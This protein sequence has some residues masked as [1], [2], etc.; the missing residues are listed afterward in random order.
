MDHDGY[1]YLIVGG[2]MAADAAVHGIREVDP[3]GTIG[4][5]SAEPDPPYKR[6][7]L[8][9]KLWHGKALDSIWLSTDQLGV[10]LHLG[11]TG[12]LLDLQHKR[13]VDDRGTEYGFDKLLLAT[14]VTPRR[15]PSAAT[16]S[17]T[18]ARSRTTSACGKR[19][20]AGSASP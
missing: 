12:R 7:P 2:G 20:R 6:P 16:G 13:V 18:T 3:D 10:D 4:L 9:K 1:T 17:P 11:R 8:S 15:L 19:Q 5:I 14:G